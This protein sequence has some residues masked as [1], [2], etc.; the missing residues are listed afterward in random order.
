MTLPI[1]VKTALQLSTFLCA[2]LFFTSCSSSDNPIALIS[3]ENSTTT[4]VAIE[5][6]D[7]PYREFLLIAI[8][9][10][11]Q[12]W[13]KQYSEAYGGCVQRF[14]RR[15]SRRAAKV[16]RDNAFWLRILR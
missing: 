9:D 14:S 2:G 8:E 11:S 13:N 15:Y 16:K 3:S 5:N 4:T 6:L 7:L 1:R 10:I 12:F